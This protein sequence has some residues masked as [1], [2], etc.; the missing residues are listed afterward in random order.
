M[1]LKTLTLSLLA[2]LP[3]AALADWNGSYVGGSF[4]S[5][6]NLSYELTVPS[7]GP[8]VEFDDTS[9]VGA[10]FGG[11]ISNGNF[12]Y[13]YEIA[14]ELPSDVSEFSGGATIDY[15]LDFKL[16]GGIPAGSA[17]FYGILGVSTIAGDYGPNE[18]NA[19]GLSF[20]G[21]AAL[22]LSNQ[23]SIGAEYLTRATTAEFVETDVETS[24]D[25]VSVRFAYHF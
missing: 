3:T 22:K 24:A 15:I 14:L 5:V 1:S 2:L 23:F 9:S 16:T 11:H 4:G 19:G 21:G 20:G 25:T 8:D 12:T 18:I 17:L 7:E 13:G 10:F 6:T